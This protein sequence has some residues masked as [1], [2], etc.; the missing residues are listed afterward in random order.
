MILVD[1]NVII[2]FWEIFFLI[3]VSSLV[4]AKFRAKQKDYY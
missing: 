2:D 1:T 4:G 3:I